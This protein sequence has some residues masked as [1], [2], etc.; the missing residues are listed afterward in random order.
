MQGKSRELEASLLALQQ[1]AKSLRRDNARLSEQS[2]LLERLLIGVSGAAVGTSHVSS[3]NPVVSVIMPTRQRAHVLGRAVRSVLSQTFRQWELIIVD[4]GSDDHGDPSL[5]TLFTDPRIFVHPRPFEGAASARNFGLQRARGELIAYLDSDCA[6]FPGFLAAAVNAFADDSVDLVYGALVTSEHGLNG[7]RTLFDRFDRAGLL[8]GNFIDLNVVVHRRVLVGRYGGFDESLTRLMDWDL[9]LRYTADRAPL[10]LPVIAAEYGGGLKDRITRI[11]TLGD[12]AFKI[13]QKWQTI[14]AVAKD[15][16]VLYVIWHY[17]QLSETYIE[18]EIRGML[19]WG[20][21]VEVWCETGPAASYP[22]SVPVHRGSLAEAIEKV[23]PHLLHIH[24]ITFGREQIETFARFGLPITARAHGFEFSAAAMNRILEWPW[25][26]RLYL[27]PH[28]V[29]ADRPDP[30]IRM[31]RSAFDSRLFAPNAR[32]NRHLAVR[33]GAALP[34]KD[35]QFCFELA[36]RVPDVRFVVAAVTCKKA[37]GYVDRLKEDWADSGTPCELMFDVPREEIAK[38]VGQAGIYLHTLHPPGHPKGTAIGMPV[39]IAEAMA[40][41]A[42]VLFRDLPEL[43]GYVEDAGTPY[44][45]MDSAAEAVA[46]IAGMADD[47]W[48]PLYIRSVDRAFSLHADADVY[49]PVVKD[50]CEIAF[51]AI[52]AAGAQTPDGGTGSNMTAEGISMVG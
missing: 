43:R 27:F 13:R 45:D 50:W 22:P 42:H 16:R 2:V 26:R 11:A 46:R 4:D 20:V 51:A 29:P 33:T 17:P 24:W 37:E 12:N 3:S 9:L 19:R 35:L 21:T 6:W 32:K 36:K 7:R 30:R 5:A 49:R 41:G 34:S 52:G 28:Q 23:R 18:T 10:E 48:R 40:T 39:S 15:L 1:E 25:L 8:R 38:L 44:T 31:I 47:A 14:P